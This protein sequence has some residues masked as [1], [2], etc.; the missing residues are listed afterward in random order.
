[1]VTQSLEHITGKVKK[2][3]RTERGTHTEKSIVIC[4]KRRMINVTSGML[5]RGRPS[6]KV[7]NLFYRMEIKKQENPA[8]LGIVLAYIQVQL[9]DIGCSPTRLPL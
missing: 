6:D 8:M 7:R 2:P 3:R 1:M 9:I 5:R 4:E